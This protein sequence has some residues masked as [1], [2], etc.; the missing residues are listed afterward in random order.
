MLTYLVV[1]LEDVVQRHD[2]ATPLRLE[3]KLVV[4]DRKVPAEEEVAV[5]AIPPRVTVRVRVGD[6]G[7]RS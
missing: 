1:L 6:W 5:D 3:V 4:R 7:F 2:A